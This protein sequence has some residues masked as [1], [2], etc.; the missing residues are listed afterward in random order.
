VKDASQKELW[1]EVFVLDGQG[2]VL[3]RA[4]IPKLQP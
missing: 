1:A 2:A 4:A 3:S